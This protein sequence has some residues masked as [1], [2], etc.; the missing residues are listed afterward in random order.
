[1]LLAL[2]QI[3]SLHTAVNLSE[4]LR[5]VLRYFKLESSF[6]NAITNNASKNAA[7]LDLLGDKLLIDIRKRH[8]RCIGHVINLVA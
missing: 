4:Q 6:G 2:P 3:Y 8:V 1:V 7:C 5:S